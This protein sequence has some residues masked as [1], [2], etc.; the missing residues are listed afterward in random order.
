MCG[1]GQG[2]EQE[3]EGEKAKEERL[4]TSWLLR[5]RVD[6]C[7]DKWRTTLIGQNTFIRYE[8]RASVSRVTYH[9]T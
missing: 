9:L 7:V 4:E 3:G 8:P 1:D 2:G 6:D 5:V